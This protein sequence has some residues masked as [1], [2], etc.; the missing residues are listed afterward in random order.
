MAVRLGLLRASR[1]GKAVR[2]SWIAGRV[3]RLRLMPL[4]R[5]A[6]ADARRLLDE[7]WDGVTLPVDPVRIAKGL[8]I[9]VVDVFLKENVSGAL[10]K[11]PG[12][13]PS[14]LLNANDSKNRK[15]FTCAHELGHFVRRKEDPDSYEYIDYRNA[16]SGTGLSEDERYANTFA[17]TLLMPEEQV[18]E[19][20][21]HGLT[22]VEMTK[23]FGV[24]REAMQY[25]L[26]NLGLQ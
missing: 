20:H 4:Q 15:R 6:A 10:V 23:R 1:L 18:R 14:I 16:L 19:L 8:G 9:S 3:A 24:S 26:V 17:A 5:E 7:A 25:R 21:K 13:D 11:K 12:Q 2:A 22:E